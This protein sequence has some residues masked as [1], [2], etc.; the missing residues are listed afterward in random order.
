MS[1]SEIKIKN[2]DSK[3][4]IYIGSD[5]LNIL[6]KKI[7]TVCP[8]AV[9]IALIIDKNIP[10]N[11]KFLIKKILKKY[12]LISFEYNPNEKLKSFKNAND[13]IEI[14]LK[15]K[16]NRSDVIIALGGGIIGDFSAFVASV[17]KRG[18][19][20]INLPST[21]L[22]QVDSSIG[23]KTGLNSSQGK[24][25][26]GTFYQPKLVI[27]DVGLLR[28]LPKREI[29]CGF[30]EM[31]KHSLILKNNYFNWLKLN[32]Q[33]LLESKD[34][35]LF[36]SAVYKNCKIKLHFVNKDV[37]E[38]STRMILNFGH[39][40]AHAIEIKNGYSNKINHGEAV[41]MGMMII[42][43]LSYIKKILPKSSLG[44]I[45]EVYESN[46]LNYNLKKYFKK[47]DFNKIIDY[48]SNDKKNF[49]KKINF[50]L[51]RDIGKT[52]NP[53]EFTMST[54]EIKK[55]FYKLI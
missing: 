45:I 17:V 46:N 26:I 24:N 2:Q 38:S 22:S 5:I 6:P 36:Q 42:A 19:N 33:K 40:F 50:I 54:K 27:S 34:L 30:A 53:G 32:S 13:L 51:L 23:G 15:E 21:L 37:K 9:K 49:N 28:S 16:F 11:Y 55:I 44:K 47:K 29:I 31:L 3:Y 8:K 1:L 10:K 20:F 35:R 14:L 52:S 7:R 25:L 4:S 39:T 18:C 12:E 43:K 41:L 48:M